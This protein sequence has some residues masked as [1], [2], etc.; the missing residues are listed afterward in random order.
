MCDARP[1]CDACEAVAL[2]LA[3]SCVTQAGSLAS[4]DAL[5][6]QVAPTPVPHSVCHTMHTQHR[7]CQQCGRFQRVEEFNG[8]RRSC[9][10]GLRA[11]NARRRSC[12]SDMHARTAPKAKKA[13]SQQPAASRA[14]APAAA[15]APAAVQEAGASKVA[16][17]SP[18][19]AGPGGCGSTASGCTS[20]GG[21]SLHSA[22]RAASAAAAAGGSAGAGAQGGSQQCLPMHIPASMPGLLYGTAQ[23]SMHVPQ[24][25]ALVPQ[26]LGAMSG[27]Q[28]LSLRQLVQP[29]LA[30]PSAQQ[31]GAGHNNAASLLVAGGC[32]PG[33]GAVQ[34]GGGVAGHL[35]HT[36]CHSLLCS[37]SSSSGLSVKLDTSP[38]AGLS[39]QPPIIWPGCSAVGVG[40]VGAASGAS[41]L[42]G[43][44]CWPGAHLPALYRAHSLT[45][46]GSS[47]AAAAAAVRFQQQQPHG[48]GVLDACA[49]SAPA[50][51]LPPVHTTPQLLQQ[52]QLQPQLQLPSIKWLSPHVNSTAVGTE[53]GSPA[54]D[55][56]SVFSS[57][58]AAWA[59][60]TLQQQQLAAHGGSPA[61]SAWPAASAGCAS[62]TPTF[63]G[64]ASAAA[65]ASD[66]AAA[67]SA[68][69]AGSPVTTT[70]ATNTTTATA[71]PQLD[72]S[73]AAC[74][75]AAFC[76]PAA[77]DDDATAA[78]VAAVE[79]DFLRQLEDAERAF[80][81]DQEGG[82]AAYDGN[83]DDAAAS[84]LASDDVDAFLE[85][86]LRHLFDCRPDM[87]LAV[88]GPPLTRLR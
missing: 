77:V 41:I 72:G 48:A 7:F 76:P 36:A 82:G 6:A 2:V 17:T 16:A 68:Q 5:D 25:M 1:Q 75:G 84:D 22:D 62:E 12:S 79:D 61:V 51:F 64:A 38:P 8:E 65:A 63:A 15:P 21:D 57:A 46:A 67:G 18:Q 58:S 26:Q 56:N 43:Q 83:V 60:A 23:S 28:H 10:A 19:G 42:S 11:H 87:V 66:A 34:P 49:V 33:G 86:A 55:C 70:T 4:V 37:S 13:K 32:I 59:S 31:Q 78:A 80:V 20:G 39:C 74:G 71:G 35:Q 81:A 88:C 52:S 27:V 54:S 53:A 44:G 47:G 9:H 73:A 45:A 3:G 14:A 69:P 40:G 24:H 50:A 30:H 85:G 29:M